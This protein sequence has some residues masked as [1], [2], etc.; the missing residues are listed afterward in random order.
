MTSTSCVRRAPEVSAYA[1]GQAVEQIRR[2]AVPDVS[3]FGVYVRMN[4]KPGQRDTLIER[5]KNGFK[6]ALQVGIPGLE[7]FSINVVLDDPDTIW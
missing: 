5:F 4:A 3:R 2:T 6:D 7:S 1:D